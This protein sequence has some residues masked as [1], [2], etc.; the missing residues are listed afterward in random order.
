VAIAATVAVL[1]VAAVAFLAEP[2]GERP[3]ATS[4]PTPTAGGQGSAASAGCRAVDPTAARHPNLKGF[5]VGSTDPDNPDSPFGDGPYGLE[6]AYTLGV[7]TDPG[8]APYWWQPEAGSGIFIP[9][10]DGLLGF[11]PTDSACVTRWNVSAT[12]ANEQGEDPPRPTAEDIRVLNAASVPKAVTDFSVRAPA[13]GDWLVRAAVDYWS[14]NAGPARI[15]SFFRV[16]VGTGAAPT[17]GP[18]PALDR[19][20]TIPCGAPDTEARVP[21]TLSLSADGAGA[22]SAQLGTFSWKLTDEQTGG[23]VVPPAEQIVT[24]AAGAT[25]EVSIAGAVC[26]TEW[27]FEYGAIPTEPAMRSTFPLTPRVDARTVNP[28]RGLEN[29]FTFGAPLSGEWLVRATL[30]Y[31]DGD[32][33]YYWR[34]V[35]S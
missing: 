28:G 33:V 1:G 9:N 7:Q 31:E 16:V 25:L 35:V 5:V 10:E 32:G 14:N 8:P 18:T 30:H 29:R 34:V 11:V 2:T 3:R 19:T 6:G 24:M 22:T 21:P 26:A 23:D 17:S 13:Q 12:S 15:E 27:A 20:P 4:S